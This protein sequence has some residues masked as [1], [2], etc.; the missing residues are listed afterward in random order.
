MTR[1]WRAWLVA[2]GILHAL[3]AAAQRFSFAAMGDVPYL[4]SE[5]ALV[6]G[7]LQTLDSEALAFVIH[8]GDFKSGWSTCSDDLYRDRLQLFNASRHPL[9]YV[10]GDNEWTDCD[11]RDCGAYDPVERLGRLR[12]LFYA[13][14]KTLGR[15]RFALERQSRDP[16]YADYRENARWQR[17][18][19]LFV[20]I[21]VPG[22][23]NNIGKKLRPSE[24]FV[25]RARANSAWLASSFARARRDRLTG[26]VIA[27]QGDPGF[28]AASTGNPARGYRELLQLL[29]A[30]SRAFGGQVLLIHGDSHIH[31]LDRP[32]RNPSNGALAA[33]FRR[34]IVYGSPFMGWDKISVDD[35]RADPFSFEARPYS[36]HT[37]R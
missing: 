6:P 13:D 12:Q 11:R 3:P 30:E 22:S 26:I 34:L 10:P 21:N 37:N 7:L 24:E 27:M 29:G 20:A 5:R 17:G 16:A 23:S 4:D 19:I 36:A 31:R 28:E 2:L 35:E 1:R 33:N 15:S 25:A 9:I 14:D 32:M 18:K 8:V